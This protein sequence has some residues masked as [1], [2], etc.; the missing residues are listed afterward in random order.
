MLSRIAIGLIL[1]AAV[2][3]PAQTLFPSTVYGRVWLTFIIAGGL[4]GLAYHLGFREAARQAEVRRQ[5]EAQARLDQLDSI[6]KL[7]QH[8]RGSHDKSRAWIT[9][10]QEDL[11]SEHFRD[12][13][14][15][16]SSHMFHAELPY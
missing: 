13:R 12:H 10:H 14:E 15:R 8:L 4:A 2:G 3:L 7:E 6:E 1:G 16:P 9:E 5:F 11:D